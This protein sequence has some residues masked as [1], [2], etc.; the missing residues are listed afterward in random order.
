MD[1]IFLGSKITADGDHSHEI[2]RYLLLGRKAKT[3]LG[4]VLKSREI[5]L[6]TKVPIVKVMVFPV[7]MYGCE[8]VGHK[9]G[10]TLKNWYFQTVVL[11]KTLQSP[12]DSKKIKQ[13]N[14]KGNQPWIFIGKIGAK[15]PIL[16]APEVK[17]WLTWKDPDAGKNWGQEEKGVTEDEMAGWHHWLNG[18][19]YEQTP[20]DG[21]EQGSLVCY[22]PWGRKESDMTERLNNHITNLWEKW[23]WVTIITLTAAWQSPPRSSGSGACTDPS[24]GV[25][26]SSEDVPSWCCL[27]TSWVPS[28]QKLLASLSPGRGPSQPAVE[29]G[30]GGGL[31]SASLHLPLGGGGGWGV[32]YLREVNHVY[33]VLCAPE[34]AVYFLTGGA[35]I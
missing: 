28:E 21:E 5:T 25:L 24:Q 19:E 23:D 34:G 35:I 17:S 8:R 13:V 2:Q 20:A 9:E 27:G 3:N 33:L 30:Q 31:C 12:L 10:W 4:S 18:Q 15:A 32:K 7:V 26:G 14:P 11:E 29:P 1:F 22:S 16:W 6:L